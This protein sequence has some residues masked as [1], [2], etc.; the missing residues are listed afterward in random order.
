MCVGGADNYNTLLLVSCG[1][2]SDILT[3]TEL[4]KPRFI[5]GAW[6]YFTYFSFGF[7]PNLNINQDYDNLWCDNYD[8][9]NTK[10]LSWGTIYNCVRLGNL[11]SKSNEGTI[12]TYRKIILIKR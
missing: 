2:C 1:S 5:N 3:Y 9:S 7:S 6:W 8:S 11:N 4:N 10:R 12:S